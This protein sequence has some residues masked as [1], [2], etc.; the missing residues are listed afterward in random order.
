LDQ[1]RRGVGRFILGEKD[2]LPILDFMLK[3]FH[4]HLSEVLSIL[5]EVDNSK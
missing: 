1:K 5:E 2:Y 4:E 3:Y